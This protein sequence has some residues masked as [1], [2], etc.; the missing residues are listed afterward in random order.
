M[1]AMASG[2]PVVA[3]DAM[4]LPHLVHDGDNGYL[5]PPDDVDAFAGRLKDVLTASPEELERLSENSLFLIKSHDI[6]RTLAIFE[7]LYIGAEGVEP[8]DDN[9][10][11]YSQPIGR[12]DE[13]F[14]EQI[15]NFRRRRD[16]MVD[17][18][19]VATDELR[20]RFDEIRLAARKVDRRVRIAAK[21]AQKRIRRER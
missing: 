4:A 8:S 2:R 19:E 16:A 13:A 1:E 9:L 21:R 7:K 14:H 11:E 15:L 10:P 6:Q 18:V 20:E 17:R 3:A 5:F 12:L